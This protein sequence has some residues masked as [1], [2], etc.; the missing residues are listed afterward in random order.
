M[1]R[2]TLGE[3]WDGSVELWGGSRRFIRP[4]ERSRTG[5]GNL[6]EVRDGLADPQ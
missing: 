6:N 2:G 1:G 4:S 5:R 3:V